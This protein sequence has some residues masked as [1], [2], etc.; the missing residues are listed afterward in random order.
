MG[1]INIR[2]RQQGLGN[3][4]GVRQVDTSPLR[5]VANQDMA[6]ARALAGTIDDLVQ[7][8]LRLGNALVEMRA[9]DN[10]NEANKLYK[11][12]V[13]YMDSLTSQAADPND[14]NGRKEGLFLTAER[15]DNAAR[16]LSND[17]RKGQAD[18]RKAIGLDKQNERVKELF[19]EM[20]FSYDRG[21]ALRADAIMA[22][23]FHDSRLSNATAVAELNQRN[24]VRD[25]TWDSLA[26]AEAARRDLYAVQGLGAN[27][28][29]LAEE[30][31]N[32][33][34]LGEYLGQ[35]AT[36]NDTGK[37]VAVRASLISKDEI[38]FPEGT[39]ERVKAFM[40]AEWK[41][42]PTD[43]K[44]KTI[45]TLEA[46]RDKQI[47]QNADFVANMQAEG[48]VSYNDIK[49]AR[50]TA[51]S[52]GASESVLKSYNAT[53]NTQLTK[54]TNAAILGA[55]D[56]LLESPDVKTMEDQFKTYAAGLPKHVTD[57]DAWK[58][59]EQ[60]AKKG[61]AK[62]Y[63]QAQKDIYEKAA[64]AITYGYDGEGAFAPTDIEVRKQQLMQMVYEGKIDIED[65]DK[66]IKTM[67]VMVDE[68]CAD[69]AQN[70]L[71]A[72]NALQRAGA[73]DYE[74][75]D[76]YAKNWPI[77]PFR[78]GV[79]DDGTIDTSAIASALKSL[80]PNK[81][82]E[83]Y[84]QAAQMFRTGYTMWANAVAENPTWTREEIEEL[85][86]AST[87][88][89]YEMLYESQMA[90]PDYKLDNGL[91]P[92]QDF[93]NRMRLLE[94]VANPYDARVKGKNVDFSQ[95]HL[96]GAMYNGDQAGISLQ[97]NET[98]FG[99]T[100]GG[101]KVQNPNEAKKEE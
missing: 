4:P 21:N 10:R 26:A 17:L 41:K 57:S 99:N 31:A 68:R 40:N 84:E 87:R 58:T 88:Y 30:K 98:T 28:I 75:E 13:T 2:F 6:S 76:A 56:S 5:D 36:T 35:L 23:R 79:N 50:E 16:N 86:Y 80:Y 89:A 65:A 83:Q 70:A 51:R 45:K 22:K 60:K 96:I 29:T 19:E 15:D 12:Y 77:A 82:Q 8:G 20:A 33:L 3:L 66:R 53:L 1:T 37:L 18:T 81:K 48:R 54:E 71:Y 93:W 100:P 24:A 27:E 64:D 72:H 74:G 92:E 49:K 78:E 46:E 44:N 38:T 67:R 91:T 85:F 14:P 63:Q 43:V 94:Q 59:F 42:L 97:T 55:P 61:Y 34:L 52:L 90:L 73:H 47:K 95:P 32:Q 7:G 69:I 11:D 62:V 9:E 39:D 101:V 25:M